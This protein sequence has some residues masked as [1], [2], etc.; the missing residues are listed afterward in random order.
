VSG[1]RIGITI[2]YFQDV[3]PDKEWKMRSSKEV[4][5]VT[6]FLW[7]FCKKRVWVWSWPDA[8][9]SEHSLMVS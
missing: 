4:R 9:D 7:R 8:D 6:A 1:L 3:G 2:A 5:W